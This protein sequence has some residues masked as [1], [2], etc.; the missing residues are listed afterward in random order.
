MVLSRTLAITNLNRTVL[1]AELNRSLNDGWLRGQGT[2]LFSNRD[3][4]QDATITDRT[5]SHGSIR[6]QD[7]DDQ[8]TNR[9]LLNAIVSDVALNAITSYVEQTVV[10]SEITQP[11]ANLTERIAQPSAGMFDVTTQLDAVISDRLQKLDEL[12]TNLGKERSDR[13][14]V[15]LSNYVS[16][17]AVEFALG[18]MVSSLVEQLSQYRQQLATDKIAL[19]SCQQ[20][21]NRVTA[22]RAIA[23]ITNH[24]EF[25][26]IDN[27]K[28]VPA[29][30][31]LA[32]QLSLN[33]TPLTIALAQLDTVVS[34]YLTELKAAATVLKHKTNEQA[35]S[36]VSNYV[37]SSSV[38]SALGETVSSLV[39]Q[40]SQYRQQLATDK[41]NSSFNLLLNRLEPVSNS[42][43]EAKLHTKDLQEAQAQV[44]TETRSHSNS[45]NANHLATGYQLE[46][47]NNGRKS[48]DIW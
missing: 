45:T 12:K 16:S 33:K 28:L 26:A 27:S 35:I 5:T 36:T 40:F 7:G 18:K 14:T 22:D 41:N 39:E 42:K 4:G 48:A 25:E 30:E 6:G 32:P 46:M 20:L 11:I 37:N 17:S 1:I 34:N 3:D 15:A 38:E 21:I 13:A 9:Q 47:N 43:Q 24:V 44:D 8:R 23:A 19:K 10:K 29:L 31:S 2:T